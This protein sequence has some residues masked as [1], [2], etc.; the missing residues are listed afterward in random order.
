MKI[1]APY[2]A[3]ASYYR[4]ARGRLLASAGL[5]LLRAVLLAPIPI[6]VGRAIDRAIPEGEISQ[7]V[8]IGAG[9]L[10][11]TAL[12]AAAQVA[13]KAVG[14]TTT[15]NAIARLRVDTIDRLLRV[16]RR[17]Y[18]TTD[19]GTLHDH[20]INET[21]RI[22][23]G[24]SAVIDDYL[25]GSIVIIAISV[26]LVQMNLLLTVV[27][28]AFG[29][30]IYLANKILGR[31]VDQQIGRS[32]HSFERMSRGVLS[33]LRSMDL[34]RI[35]GAESHESRFQEAVIT[36]HS[37]NTVKRAVGVTIYQVTQHSLIAMSGTAVLVIGGLSVINGGMTIGDLISFYAGF[38]LLKGPL[39]GLAHRAPAVI[40]GRRSLMRLYEL[41]GD[42]DDRPYKGTKD[43]GLMGNIAVEGVTFA[44]EER[45]VLHDVSLR[46]EPGRV[47]GLVG[48][49]GSGKSTL[50]NLIVGFYR[51]DH[52]QLTADGVHYDEID[53]VSL[54]RRMG[55]VP[56]QP[57]LRNATILENIVYGRDGLS[58]EDVK[59]A[60]HLA[61]ATEFIADLPAG[62]DTV[63][64]EEGVFLSG[65]QRQRVAIARAL[66][67]RPPLLILDEPTNHLD[68]DSVGRVI[69]AISELAPRPAVLVVSHRTEVL[70]GV[71]EIVEL[72]A[73]RVQTPTI[74]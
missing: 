15:K 6:L 3:Y 10:L 74:S 72:R 21:K 55:I 9:I 35:Q 65:G 60:L 1:A 12:S 32:N 57:E 58:E 64:G 7:L 43:I 26:V 53:M 8:L 14:A 24:S 4:R 28:V 19:P 17:Q 44:Y 20:V 41:I 46:L 40:E 33:M 11:F 69:E 5:S 59:L 56:Q 38:A 71:D 70:S 39:S 49:N 50:V 34:I 36:E 54:R 29:P 52:G 66:V 13:A 23:N 63:V 68:R 45:T 16:S 61:Q 67:H 18:S 51:P 30:L 62:V 73:G 31:W 37:A 22:E 2:R 42:D 25:P 27:T 47:T 48:P